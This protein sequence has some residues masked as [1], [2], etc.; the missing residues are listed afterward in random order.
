[1]PECSQVTFFPLEISTV[2]FSDLPSPLKS[3]KKK[4]SRVPVSTVGEACYSWT[5]SLFWLMESHFLGYHT[6]I[7]MYCYSAFCFS[8]ESDKYDIRFLDLR[9]FAYYNRVR[10]ALI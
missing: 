6:S 1:M 3:I 2:R 4:Q 9:G 5:S 7:S 10:V 8:V